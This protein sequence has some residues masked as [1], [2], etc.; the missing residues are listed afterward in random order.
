MCHKNESQFKSAL[1]SFQFLLHLVSEPLIQSTKRL[2]EQEHVRL[3][4]QSSGQ[5]H[6]LLLASAELM[7]ETV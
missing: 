6:A 7:G 1:Q 5:G 2:V 4:D 3:H